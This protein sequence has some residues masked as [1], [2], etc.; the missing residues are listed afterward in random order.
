VEEIAAEQEK[1]GHR[2]RS[3]INDLQRIASSGG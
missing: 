2:L 1:V 3:A